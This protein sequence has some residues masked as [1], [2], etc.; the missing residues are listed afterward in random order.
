MPLCFD[1]DGTL[2]SFGGGYLL[3]R[4]TL[5]ELWG[6]PVEKAEL[7]ACAGS[8]DWEIVDE[9][10]RIRFGHGL[11]EEAYGAFE[12]ACLAKFQGAFH[13]EGRA[14]LPHAGLIEG[15]SLLLERGHGIWLVSGNSPAVLDFKAEALGL[16]PRIRRLGSLPGHDRAGLIRH[17]LDRGPR[18]HL[19]AG[20]R[21]HDRDAAKAAGVPFLAV[22]DAAPGDHP[23]LA[24]HAEAE[25]LVEAVEK[26]LA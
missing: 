7:D 23:V 26:L 25:A 11:D 1:L 4:E 13:P 17:A 2:G 21:P 6:A 10:R 8:T 5:A 9:L 3:L 12:R 19:Y 22:G 16:D 24:P 18:P 20:D 14:P 15:L